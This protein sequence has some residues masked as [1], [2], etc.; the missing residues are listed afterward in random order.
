MR[1][2]SPDFNICHLLIRKASTLC[3][4]KFI[5]ICKKKRKKENKCF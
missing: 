3:K 2:S 1:K 4:F 5:D